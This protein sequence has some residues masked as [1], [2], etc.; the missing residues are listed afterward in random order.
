MAPAPNLGRSRSLLE[1][2]TILTF[3]IILVSLG[4]YVALLIPYQEHALRR[5]LA[6]SAQDIATSVGQ[7]MATAMLFNDYS[8]I[9]DHCMLV[10]KE[11]PS[12]S[13]VIITRRN[14]SSLIHTAEGWREDNLDPSWSPENPLPD[15]NFR[16]SK[17]V[18]G[19]VFHLSQKF[20]FSG[21]EWGWIHVG[22]TLDEFE[23]D[24]LALYW[25]LLYAGLTCL[26]LGLL[27]SI[28]FAKRLSRPII[29]LESVAQQLGRGQL[30]A[31]AY[32]TS[33]DEIENLAHTINW[34]AQS[35]TKSREDLLSAWNYADN[36]IKSMRDSLIVVGAD[37]TIKTANDA[38]ATMLG[39]TVE[40]LEGMSIESFLDVQEGRESARRLLE[41]LKKGP[42]ID[43]DTVFRRA[44]KTRVPVLLSG[45]TLHG[46]DTETLGAVLISKDISERIEAETR[47]K[48]SLREKEVMLREIH[49]RVK[50]NMQVISSL[51]KLQV[52]NIDD[53]I[54]R[55]IITESQNRIRSM[56]LIHEKLYLSDNFAEVDF[57][58]YAKTLVSRLYESY[59]VH[60]HAIRMEIDVDYPKLPVDTAIPCGLIVNELVSNALKHAFSE[61]DK[62]TITVRMH[63]TSDSLIELSVADDGC[64][65]PKD[66]DIA[67]TES[68]GLRLVTMLA[69]DQ[70]QA[71]LE[72][73]RK[74]GLKTTLRFAIPDVQKGDPLS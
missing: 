14:N 24:R 23:Q 43:L 40:E 33:G 69:E 58:T 21:V 62:G 27:A 1:R 52:R 28:A 19:R 50:N 65:L 59:G 71:E 55:G 44:D 48:R 41:F 54:A 8:S 4:S 25:R 66:L 9:V 7:A 31:R 60:Q 35:L 15:G 70:L 67:T 42:S 37:G 26:V 72:F 29:E 63:Q 16:E 32:I 20:K 30:Q 22:L 51:L 57:R 45:A 5:K 56:A 13:Y 49:H 3:S 74:S 47:L 38:S 11:R 17:I 12:I 53:D 18:A 46:D 39:H 6:S 2:T 10:V 68:L 73:C 36:I 34:M 61:G 64:G